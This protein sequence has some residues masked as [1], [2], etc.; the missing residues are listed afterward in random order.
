VVSRRKP[1]PEYTEMFLKIPIIRPISASKGLLILLLGITSLAFVQADE[2]PAAMKP[3]VEKYK[4]D[5]AALETLRQTAIFTARQKYDAAMSVSETA[6]LNA[7]Q[8][9]VVAAITKEREA[10]RNDMISIAPAAELPKSLLPARKTHTDAVA[11][12][13][14]EVGNRHQKLIV[15]YIR[16]LSS[17]PVNLSITHKFCGQS[18]A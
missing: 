17:L 9:N 8:L 6:A 3:L 18:P 1:E 14:T 2:F 12:I 16:S 10:V 11:A 7:G 4:T 13:D 5:E 15:E